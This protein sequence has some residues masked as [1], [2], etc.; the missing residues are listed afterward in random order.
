MTKTSSWRSRS[1][2]VVLHLVGAIGLVASGCGG[3][4]AKAKPDTGVI[5]G[6]VDGGN[7]DTI[8]HPIDG[9]ADVFVPTDVFVPVT[10]AGN[11]PDVQPPIRRS[12]SDR[13][14]PSDRC[15]ASDRCPNRHTDSPARWRDAR[16]LCGAQRGRHGD[17]RN[18][19]HRRH[20]RG[21]RGRID[22][23]RR[24]RRRGRNDRHGRN[25][26]HGWHD[27]PHRSPGQLPLDG[28]Q[29]RS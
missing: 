22:R 3:S 20:G 9:G 25:H 17:R 1:N 15:D 13:C 6:S 29:L 12:T 10:E 21:W 16:H 28:D 4:S 14:G 24:G 7:P 23:H 19:R 26:Q 18:H 8:T 5:A 11:Q 2:V 27:R